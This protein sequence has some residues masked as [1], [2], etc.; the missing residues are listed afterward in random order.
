MST[1]TKERVIGD[2]VKWEQPHEICRKK[3]HITVIPGATL[4][5]NVG[6][7]LEP[8]GAV[9]Q[10]HT[11]TNTAGAPTADGG[12]FKLGY[13]GQWTTALAFGVTLAAAKTAF[14][15]LS[16]VTDTVTFSASPA[17]TGTTCTWAT[18]GK[19]DDILWDTR[20]LLDGAVVCGTLSPVSTGGSTAAGSGKIV[21][22]GANADYILLEKVSLA[23]LIAEPLIERTVLYQGDCI[24]DG[25]QLYT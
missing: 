12:T 11:T 13:K 6:D 16:T 23:D 3:L 2:V 4:A 22:T 1:Q 21:A 14:E 25:D 19:K 17:I 5:L 7:C 8:G 18:A 24:V 20:L 9:A 15:L 10:V